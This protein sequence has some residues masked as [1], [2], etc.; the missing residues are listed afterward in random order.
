MGRRYKMETIND[1]GLRQLEVLKEREHN[2]TR[3]LAAL[4]RV[5]P[6]TVLRGFCVN[7]NYLGLRPVKLPNKRL[8]WPS[9]DVKNIL[10]K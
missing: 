3:E 4:L 10:K 8:L 2:T 5:E 1:N 6:Q 7:G 9:C